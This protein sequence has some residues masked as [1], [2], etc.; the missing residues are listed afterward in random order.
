MLILGYH[1][2]EVQ[3]ELRQKY[4]LSRI[5]HYSTI[6]RW[7][8]K[9]ATPKTRGAAAYWSMLA[10]SVGKILDR[11]MD[12]LERMSPMDVLEF[13]SRVADIYYGLRERA[14]AVEFLERNRADA[15]ARI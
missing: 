13:A 8:Q 6:A 3:R 15:A 10:L 5:P 9:M 2:R 4:P 11:R 1:C 14:N 7:F 12:E